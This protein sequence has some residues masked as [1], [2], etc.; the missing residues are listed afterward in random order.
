MRVQ[1]N[2]IDH[3]SEQSIII[4]KKGL[5]LGF[6]IDTETLVFSDKTPTCKCS[7]SG[8]D[9]KAYIDWKIRHCVIAYVC[10]N[11][12]CE[13]LGDWQ[14]LVSEKDNI[15]DTFNMST[16]EKNKFNSAISPI[17]YEKEFVRP[18]IEKIQNMKECPCC[19]ATLSHE[20]GYYIEVLSIFLSTYNGMA[21]MRVANNRVMKAIYTNSDKLVE[22]SGVNT[23]DGIPAIFD[24]MKEQRKEKDQQYAEKKSTQFVS[25]CDLP[26]MASVSMEILETIKSTSSKLQEYVL[27]LIKLETN[28]YALRKRLSVLYAEQVD[29]EKAVIAEKHSKIFK[30]NDV[31]EQAK[32]HYAQCQEKVKQ[33]ELGN[34]DLTPPTQPQ[35]P[36]MATPGLFNKKKVLAENEALKIK[37]QTEM[38]I[39]AEQVRL[40]ETEKANR[41]EMARK[42]VQEAKQK[43]EQIKESVEKSIRNADNTISSAVMAKNMIDTEIKE[44]ETL[45][46]KLFECRNRLYSYNIVFD[47]YRNAVA[48]S[49]FYEYLMAGRC[50]SLDGA[51][52]AYNIYENEI[53]AD[54]I[55][56]QLSQVIEKLDDISES[57]FMI[58]SEIKKVNSNLE[59]LNSTMDKA[60][61]SIQNME[62]NVEQ[63]AK[64]SEV[65][66]HNSAVSAYYAKVNAELTNALGFM[67]AFK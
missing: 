60:L 31:I 22:V 3:L 38:T 6:Q 42:E 21:Q 33:Y 8:S 20:K 11:C 14:T 26:V 55:I 28:I 2:K 49:T 48:L 41:L 29:R 32:S 43:L 63:I 9:K 5:E 12:A 24:F 53:R 23:E 13:L 34:G 50:A 61:V 62:E 1:V 66:A 56:G 58:Y 40:F 44:T 51:N 15:R 46:R 39:Y 17:Y 47:K 30:Q 52:G 65:M 25:S 35:A 27:N 57:Q 7:K 59:H 10:P 36:V 45:L 37:Y 64:N 54:R 67:V 19:G 18:E 4:K 16:E